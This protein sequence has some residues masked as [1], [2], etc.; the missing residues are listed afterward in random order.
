MIDK[1]TLLCST[2]KKKK[3]VVN[4]KHKTDAG[5]RN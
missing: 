2:A 4:Q 3:N 5:S 1:T